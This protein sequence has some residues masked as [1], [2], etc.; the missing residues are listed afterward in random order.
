MM[1]SA[2]AAGADITAMT[3]SSTIPCLYCGY[4]M[5]KSDVVDGNFD[6]PTR[7]TSGKTDSLSQVERWIDEAGTFEVAKRLLDA[8]DINKSPEAILEAGIINLYQGIRALTLALGQTPATDEIVQKLIMSF[9]TKFSGPSIGKTPADV[10]DLA[11]ERIGSFDSIVGNA[12]TDDFLL[13]L[14]ELMLSKL[15]RGKS[16]ADKDG[17]RLAGLVHYVGETTLKMSNE[18]K[19]RLK[20]HAKPEKAAGQQEASICFIA[21]AACGSADAPDVIALRHFRDQRLRRN[22]FGRKAIQMYER[23]SPPLAAKIADHPFARWLVRWFLVRPTAWLLGPKT[24][25]E[26]EKFYG[27]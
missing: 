19:D 15:K 20:M 11:F 27:K 4:K 1:S 6:P 26:S 13:K 21:T 23:T 17:M 22:S 2:A 16:A 5:M 9:A 14:A 18:I 10:L 24:K 3:S 7:K 25:Y 8:L 12:E